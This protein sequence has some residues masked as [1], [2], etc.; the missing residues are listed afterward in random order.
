MYGHWYDAVSASIGI[1]VIFLVRALPGVTPEKAGSDIGT[2]M[3]FA[4]VVKR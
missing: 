2:K 3:T 4:L 1:E